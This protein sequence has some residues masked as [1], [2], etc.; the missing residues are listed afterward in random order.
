MFERITDS[1][2]VRVSNS[3]DSN[4]GFIESGDSRVLIDTGTGM[5]MHQIEKDLANLDVKVTDL[6]NIVLTHCHIDHIGGVEP[7]LKEATPKIH[8]HKDEAEKINVGNTGAT[9]ADTFGH[10]LPPLNIEGIL[11]EGDVL[12]FGEVKMRTLHTPGH[13]AG[14]C[15]FYIEQDSLM[16]TGDTMF[17]G[18]SFGRVD[19]PEGDAAK[20]VKSLK[21]LSEIEFQIAIPGHMGIVRQNAQRSALS[22][23][24]MAKN[25]FR[26]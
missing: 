15:C 21:R 2:Y 8:L 6:T 16:F 25:W 9:L 23:Y 22:S 18:G 13:S 5:Y 20:L 1:I 11:T 3:F 4:I 12:E 14:S 17:S 19:F 26:V 7:I 24:T 10:D